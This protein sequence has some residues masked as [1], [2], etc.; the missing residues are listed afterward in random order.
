MNGNV[1]DRFAV[2]EGRTRI[3]NIRHGSDLGGTP[4][5]FSCTE[6]A[7]DGSPAESTTGRVRMIF[8]ENRKAG[9]Y[10]ISRRPGRGCHRGIPQTFLKKQFLEE[11]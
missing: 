8:S 1:S 3:I 4:A 5:S 10:A 6:T 7:N 2:I 9:S 11:E